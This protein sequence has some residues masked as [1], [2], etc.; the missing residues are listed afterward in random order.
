MI[1][2]I[3]GIKKCITTAN[4]FKSLGID[5]IHS[6]HYGADYSEALAAKLAGIPWMYTKKI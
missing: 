1:P 6:F 4:Y 5:L 2:R 3:A